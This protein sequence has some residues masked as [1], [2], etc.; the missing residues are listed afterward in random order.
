MEKIKV[1]YLKK[2]PYCLEAFNLIDKLKQEEQYQ[3]IQI[4]FIDEQEH[5]E[6]AEQMD[7]YYV[8]TFYFGDNKIHEG[9]TTEADIVRVFD[10][11]LIYDFIFNK[12]YKE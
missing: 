4:D 11:Y 5:P 6:I 10:L 7:Y 12:D 9:A 1:F 8:P 2:C 3:D